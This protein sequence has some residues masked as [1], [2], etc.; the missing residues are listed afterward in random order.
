[1]LPRVKIN[2][3]NGALGSVAPSE[4]GVIG[5]IV[6]GYAVT[7]FFELNKPY[8][9]TSYADLLKRGITSEENDPNKLIDKCVREIYSEAPNG[10]KVWLMG[11]SNITTQEDMCDVNGVAKNLLIAARGAINIL[12][13]KCEADDTIATT[14]G[15]Y[16]GLP[17]AINKAQALAEW[18]TTDLFAPCFVLLEGRG[19]TGDA[20][21]LAPLSERDDNR[22]AVV[23]G[24]T[25]QESKGAA[26]GLLA[27]RLA[28]IPV[29]RSCARVKDGSITSTEMYI[30]GVVAEN[31][32]PGLIH[33]AGY[34]V[35]RTFV[36]KADYFWSDDKLATAVSDDYALIP[37][38][39]VIDKAY[40]I[41]YQTLIDELNDEIPVTS[42]GKIP[43]SICK[44]IQDKVET[45]II[46]TMGADGN[47]GSDPSDANDTGVVCYIDPDQ[48]IVATSKYEVS[49]KVRPF[50]YA[51]YI[52][53]KL[54][55][56]TVNQ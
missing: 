3:E 22:V 24:D 17:N 1:M 35:P 41:A 2:F 42:E 51:K 55:F 8:L 46:S 26:V 21:Q 47:L 43:L 28:A 18:A 48:N 10:T 53:V 44:F 12:V 7:D 54:G 25:E 19:Y 29:Q 49:L 11:V 31:G 14:Y 16:T 33:D 56:Q 52:D 13:I 36:G 23:I 38:R 6:T 9:L 32:N 39:R 5:L 20:S 50:G 4:D 34:I 15:I 30:A 45:A 37:R 27:G 40:R